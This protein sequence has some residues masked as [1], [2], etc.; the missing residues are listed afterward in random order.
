MKIRHGSEAMF[1][2]RFHNPRRQTVLNGPV[3]EQVVSDT[4]MVQ[5]KWNSTAG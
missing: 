4:Q 5:N 2:S 3:V 1:S